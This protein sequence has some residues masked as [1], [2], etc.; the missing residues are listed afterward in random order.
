[1]RQ[2]KAYDLSTQPDATYTFSVRQRDAAGNTSASTS[3]DYILDR[4]AP[5]PPTITSGPG[6]TANNANPTWSFTGEAGADFECRLNSGATE[7]SA[8]GLCASPKAYDLSA[9]PD[10]TYT[11]SVRQRDAAGNTSA[12]TS[13]DYA[14]DRSSPTPPTITSGPRRHGQQRQPGVVLHRRGRCRLRVPPQLRRHGD[15]R[16]ISVRQ[17]RAYDLSAQP[18]GTYTFSVR[19]RG[20]AGNTGAAATSDYTLDREAPMAPAVAAPVPNPGND[21]TPSWFFTG[22]AGAGFECR[23]TSGGG[24]ISALGTCATPAT[25]DLSG[26]PDGTYTLWVRQ[27]GAAGNTSAFA[28]ADY[29]LDRSRPA[30]PALVSGPGA[31]GSD[32]TPTWSFSG[33]AGATFSC[34]LRREGQVISPPTPCTSP[35]SYDLSA[36]PNGTYTLVLAQSDA[37]G[38]TSAATTVDYALDRSSPPPPPPGQP[39]PSGGDS[40]PAPQKVTGNQGRFCGSNRDP[41][42]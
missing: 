6:A 1:M 8:F 11:F 7:I 28:S 24:E 31:G 27:R 34:E 32:P 17:P 30:P 37:A 29:D 40:T 23:L 12:S 42:C 9:Q 4:S 2:S 41:R 18:D 25:Y 15:L 3:S 14:L 22:E 35:T 19:Q 26:R 21:S 39:T 38:N 13:S 36:Q 16:T 10:A 20:A 33:E 5:T